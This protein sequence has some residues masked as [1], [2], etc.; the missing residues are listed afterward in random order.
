M[1]D[2]DDFEMPKTA[3]KKMGRAIQ[4]ASVRRSISKARNI[5]FSPDK[6]S[7]LMPG[8][9][10]RRGFATPS[11]RMARP[12]TVAFNPFSPKGRAHGEQSTSTNPRKYCSYSHAMSKYPKKGTLVEKARNLDSVLAVCLDDFDYR[13]GVK[14]PETYEQKSNKL[15]WRDAN[16][17]LEKHV[18]LLRRLAASGYDIGPYLDEL[19]RYEAKFEDA[20]R[21]FFTASERKM[22]FHTDPEVFSPVKMRTFD[23]DY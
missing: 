4:V 11:L 14:H 1:S 22:L 17:L 2:F 23:E 15:F 20:Q 21:R 8:M 18:R 12:P 16:R 10:P 3:R 19:V 9:T 13:M 7:P 6:G 5:P